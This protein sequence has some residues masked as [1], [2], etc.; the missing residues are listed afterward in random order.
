MSNKIGTTE[1]KKL[2]IRVDEQ[3]WQPWANTLLYLPFTSDMLDHSWNNRVVTTD[4]GIIQNGYFYNDNTDT[5][6]RW[7]TIQ[8]M[9][10]LTNFT[11]TFYEKKT[12]TYANNQQAVFLYAG[13]SQIHSIDFAN[14]IRFG[15]WGW[16]NDPSVPNNWA[17]VWRLL[18]YVK[19]GNNFSFYINATLISSASR[20]WVSQPAWSHYYFWWGS[21]YYPLMWYASQLIVEDKARTAQEVS[22]YYNLTKWNYWL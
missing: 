1:P 20:A 7:F 5:N 18:T 12:W 19:N 16:P 15:V 6:S 4:I 2:Y 9:P 22:D 17:D 21:V 3:W 8:N 10:A 11:T 14:K 13:G